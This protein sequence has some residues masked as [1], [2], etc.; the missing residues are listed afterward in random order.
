MTPVR[1]APAARGLAG[2][3]DV[4]G[5]KSIA[6]RALLLGALAEGTTAITGL[7][8]SADVAASLGA[9]QALG[10]TIDRRGDVVHV[11]GRG[12]GL[13]AAGTV[14]IDCANSGTTMRLVA[15]LTAAGPGTVVLAGDASLSR[16]PMERVAAP[17]RAMGG[18]VE[19]SDGH[20]PL[21]VRGRRLQG[22]AWTLPVASAQV[23]SAILLAGLRAAGRTTVHEPLPTR[24]HTERLLGHLGARVERAEGAVA[25]EGG[26]RLRGAPVP[27]PGDPSSAAFLVVAA[28]LVPGSELVVRDVG[29]NPTRTGLFGI[30]ARMG[31]TVELVGRGEV[32][33]EPRADLRVRAAELRGITVGP[34]EIPAAIDELPVLCVA[35]ALASG[36]TRI[37]GAGEL[38]VKESDRIA[39]LEQL[40]RLGVGVRAT[41]DG[42]V[43]E[44][45]G[46]R[47]LRGG[48]IDPHGDHRIAMAFAVAG[49][50]ADGGVVI[51]DPGCVDVSFPGFFARLAAL[52]ARIE[53]GGR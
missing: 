42:L 27:L 48:R 9:A 44:G 35:A 34:E 12:L 17:L 47:R 3:A 19:T 10:A 11:G 37:S 20:A 52:G 46:G 2:T 15:G 45:S 7:P 24:D 49:L 16:R 13:G 25:I 39:A 36:E 18:E 33:G 28:L 5:D 6:H 43:I 29:V 21:T 1:V 41:A 22:I 51:E 38:R 8:A 14:R 31:G 23:K 40:G 26:Q 4:P 30:L 53:G 32:A 50:V